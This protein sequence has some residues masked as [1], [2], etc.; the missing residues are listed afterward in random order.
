MFPKSDRDTHSDDML[1]MTRCIIRV[2]V[3]RHIFRQPLC[4]RRFEYVCTFFN[5]PTLQ[6]IERFKS[7]TVYNCNVNS[8]MY[9]IGTLERYRQ[10]Q[11]FSPLHIGL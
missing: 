9:L 11:I 5:L 2:H 10:F 4:A 8:Y 3:Q 7:V 1:A 6:V